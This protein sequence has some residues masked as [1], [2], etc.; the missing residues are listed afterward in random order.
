MDTDGSGTITL[1]E[2]NTGLSRL[3]SKLTEAEIK[4]LM[5]AVSTIKTMQYYLLLFQIKSLIKC[6]LFLQLT[7]NCFSFQADVDKSGTIDYIEFI[8][9]T[10][11]RYR[12][13]KEENLYKAF[14]FFDKDGSGLVNNS[15]WKIFQEFYFYESERL[16]ELVERFH[17]FFLFLFCLLGFGSYRY[18]TRDELRQAMSDYGMGDEETI[19]EI[20]DDVD[21]DKVNFS[22]F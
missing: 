10:M 2:L 19:N 15:K 20:I 11:H 12:L 9:A 4:Q 17:F 7:M 6:V 1:E 8:T 3:G 16:L 22:L 14:Q 5:D 21:T 18:I 13:D